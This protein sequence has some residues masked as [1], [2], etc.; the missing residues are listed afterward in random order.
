MRTLLL[1]LALVSAAGCAARMAAGRGERLAAEGRWTEAL[2]SYERA[3]ARRP[4]LPG[5]TDAL[6]EARAEVVGGH[7]AVADAARE[8]GDWRACL[9]ALDA[10]NAVLPGLDATRDRSLACAAQLVAEAEAALAAGHEDVVY[11]LSAE[12]ARHLPDHPRA[13][14]LRI[15]ARERSLARAESLAS[16][17]AWPEAI[18]ALGPIDAHEPDRRD[19]TEAVRQDLRRRWADALRGQAEG[20][21]RRGDLA[22][23]LVRQAQAA[24]LSNLGSDATRRDAL[25][26]DVVAR[27]GLAVGVTSATGRPEDLAPVVTAAQAGFGP[28]VPFGPDVE[29]PSVRWAIA[30]PPVRCT[31]ERRTVVGSVDV[32]RGREPYENPDWAAAFAAVTDLEDRLRAEEGARRALDATLL[33]RRTGLAAAVDALHRAEATLE[34]RTAARDAAA[35]V[36]SNA[37]AAWS[38]AAEAFASGTNPDAGALEPARQAWVQADLAHRKADAATGAARKQHQQAA[39]R[40]R[41]HA[42][43]LSATLADADRQLARIEGIRG[44]I[45]ERRRAVAAVPQILYRPIVETVRYPIDRFTLRCTAVAEIVDPDGGARTVTG[46]AERTAE[47]H[48]AIIDAGIPE[49][50]PPGRRDEP[51][52]IDEA[53]RA[54]A[55]STT[56]LAAERAVAWRQDQLRLARQQARGRPGEALGRQIAVYLLAPGEPHEEL[57]RTLTEVFGVADPAVLLPSDR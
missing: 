34:E 35:T 21:A 17:G 12:L 55:A 50:P 19:P 6:A 54:L 27:W 32:E 44:Q 46:A 47:A 10:A 33:E 2:A 24:R 45:V 42:D 11:A 39:E 7:H 20:D 5:L 37:A 31:E 48:P 9:A 30:A 29:G 38:E 40:V 51:T 15:A 41:Q 18:A 36:L 25:R 56:A 57:R 4:N 14:E 26:R 16:L 22:S 52:L 3:A 1:A 49:R 28:A 43:A 53:R 13:P 23:A 8:A